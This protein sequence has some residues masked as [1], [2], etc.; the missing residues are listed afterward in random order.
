MNSLTTTMV[1]SQDWTFLDKSTQEYT[2]GFHLYPARMHPEIARKLIARYAKDRKKV[3]FDPFM[4]SGGVLVEAL[5][6]GNN[7]IGIDLNPFAVLL[8]RVK[9]TPLDPKKLSRI[10]E[11]VISK[12]KKDYKN[13]DF[14]PEMAPQSKSLDLKFWYRPDVLRKLQILK[15]HIFKSSNKEERSFFKICF[16]LASRKASNQRNGMY[17][18]YRIGSEELKNFEPDTF[19]IFEDICKKNIKKMDDFHTILKD[20]NNMAYPVFGN[21]ANIADAFKRADKKI[22]EGGKVHLV[23]TSPP[24]GDHRTTV[25]YGQFSKHPGLWLEL[26]EE[27]LLGVDRTGLGGTKKTK[28]ESLGSPLLEKILDDVKNNDIFIT[29]ETRKPCRTKDVYAYFCD[30]DECLA[31]IAKSLKKGKS[32]CCFVV[33]NRTV[34]RVKIPTDDIIIEL[35]KKYGFKHVETIYRTIANKAIALKNSPENITNNS[36]ET[37]T[38]ESIVVWKY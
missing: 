5:L 23:V 32:H 10:Y 30:I 7:A 19:Q 1:K 25:A 6:H 36:G 21:T 8:S 37:M 2:H 26:P 27:E 38:R 11:K 15:F 35:G 9:T 12:A 24:Y 28:T 4:G 20:S 33:A 31:Q 22:F 14:H 34:R 18:I 13:K 17:K 29:K 3:V 16:S